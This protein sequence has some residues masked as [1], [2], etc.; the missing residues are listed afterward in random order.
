[1]QL[2]TVTG[3]QHWTDVATHIGAA[4]CDAAQPKDVGVSWPAIRWPGGI[5]GCAHG[6]S[7]IGWALARLALATGDTR[8]AETA[9]AAFAFEE[10][11]YDS[12]A[13][14]W[15]DLRE[16]HPGL[17]ANA[18]CHGSVGIGLTAWDLT[19]R[20]WPVAEGLLPR[21]ALAAHTD[22]LGWNHTL[23]HGDLGVWE[24]MDAALRAGFAPPGVTREGFEAYVMASVEENGAVSGLARA[25]FSP[26]MMSGSGGVAYELLRMGEGCEL[27]SVLVLDDPF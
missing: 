22:G 15:L 8:A 12:K 9:E 17:T 16:V 2:A 27:P 6:A 23:C 5:G 1:L 13:G 20:G 7:G 26:A 14:G 25:A 24:L 10:S 21:A 18:W 11:C 19:R 4:L 3:E